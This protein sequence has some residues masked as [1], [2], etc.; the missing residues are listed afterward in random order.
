MR[1]RSRLSLLQGRVSAVLEALRSHILTVGLRGGGSR[2]GI[3]IGLSRLSGVESRC[4]GCFR[5]QVSGRVEIMTIIGTHH[6]PP[7]EQIE[8]PRASGPWPWRI[9]ARQSSISRAQ[10]ARTE[11]T[12]SKL[13]GEWKEVG[14]ITGFSFHRLQRK[15][16]QEPLCSAIAS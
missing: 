9:A 7:V 2:R 12:R 5:Y 11:R 13:G 14:E 8:D 4:G 15:K 1:H 3:A 6:H 10:K 16:Q